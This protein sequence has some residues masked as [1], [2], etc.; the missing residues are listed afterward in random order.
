MLS[1]RST[2]SITFEPERIIRP[3]Y[4]GGDVAIDATGRVLA[5]CL[6]EDV[7][8][9]DLSTGEALSRIEGVGDLLGEARPIH[10][11]NVGTGWRGCYCNPT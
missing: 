5:S 10:M 7:A 4:T 2:P 8:I 3:I 1:R 11:L 9:T 6:G